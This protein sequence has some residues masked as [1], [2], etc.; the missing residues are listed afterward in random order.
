VSGRPLV[1]VCEDGGEYLERFSRFFGDEFAFHRVQDH[2]A[3]LAACANGP[4]GI[5]CDMDFRRVPAERL[6][7]EAGNRAAGRAHDDVR[8]LAEMQGALILRALRA[9]GVTIPALLFV[10]LDDPARVHF[11]EQSLAPLVVV[12]S[13]E[14]LVTLAARLR[15][16]AASPSG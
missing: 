6:I 12:P 2:A 16:W 13:G 3:A 9:A 5:L 8:R 7:D 11:L 15:S 4:A 1:L 10:D 14:G